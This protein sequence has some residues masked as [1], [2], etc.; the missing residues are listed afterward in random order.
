MTKTNCVKLLIFILFYFSVL[1]A[2]PKDTTHK[3]FVIKALEDNESN[4]TQKAGDRW[5]LIVGVEKYDDPEINSLRYSV[6][7]AQALYDFLTDPDK[8]RF[9]PEKVKL[10]IDTAEDKRLKPTK[11][12]ILHYLNEWLA[13][14][15]KTEDTVLI[16]FSGHGMVYG[17]RKY[18]LPLDTDTFY[19]PAYAIDNEE[20]I[21]AI[22]KLKSEK[23][24]M[25][26]DSCHSGGVSRSGKGIGDV[27]SDDFYSQFES[28]KGRVTLA[29][30]DGDEQSFEW[31][32]K[33]HGVFTY[34]LLEGLRSNANK[35]GDQAITFDELA[36]YV[37]TKVS[38]W[39]KENKNGKQNPQKHGERQSTSAEIAIAFDVVAGYQMALE[40]LKEKLLGYIGKGND[41]LSF[42]EVTK[43]M[44]I[45]DRILPRIESKTA[46]SPSE[47]TAL[48]LISSLIKGEMPV[49]TYR[50]LSSAIQAVLIEPETETKT[51]I[52][53]SSPVKKEEVGYGEIRVIAKPWADIYLDER[54]VGQTP[55]I[56]KNVPA[57]QHSLTLKNPEYEQIIK[58]I[59][60][61]GNQTV[62]VREEFKK[63]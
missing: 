29:S 3:G 33:G 59:Q 47:D 10:I 51:K 16:F 9:S 8:G 62:T 7:D 45:I 46:L 44:K 49:S 42:D 43:A 37:G 19:T 53:I 20:F 56:L 54:L 23:V 22:D 39:A 61:I 6:D 60:V 14:H 4:E 13:S 63:K 41:K 58:Q 35:N 52:A 17:N 27:L 36:D 24:I 38:T 5:G 26:L 28:A 30:C 11:A 18:L 32:E 25:L 2:V 57:G 15:V 55:K 50:G 31:S 48:T 1:L 40:K 12:N 21:E 34:Y